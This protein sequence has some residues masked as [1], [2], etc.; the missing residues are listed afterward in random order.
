M[1][2]GWVYILTNQPFGPLYTGV[3]SDLGRRMAAHR[4]RQGSAFAA[5]YGLTRL[6]WV[7]HHPD[8]V[9][10]IKREKSIKRWRRA[11]KLNVIEAMNPRWVDLTD[12]LP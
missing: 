7:E 2:G 11:W 12:Q 9:T 6:V 3:T 4:A 8:I 10:A 5:K 1:Q